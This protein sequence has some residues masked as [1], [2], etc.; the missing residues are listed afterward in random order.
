M[1][2]RVGAAIVDGAGL[3][4]SSEDRTHSLPERHLRTASMG[5]GKYWFATLS[6]KQWTARWGKR[7]TEGQ[8]KTFPFPNPDKARADFE[9]SVRKKLD[10]GYADSTTGAAIAQLTQRAAFTIKVTKKPGIDRIGGAA[11]ATPPVCKGCRKPMGVVAVF[12]A[13]AERL[14][15]PAGKALAIYMCETGGKNCKTWDPDAG[16]NAAVLLPKTAF[17]SGAGRLVHAGDGASTALRKG[18]THRAIC[19][20]ARSLEWFPTWVQDPEFPRDAR[21]ARR[22]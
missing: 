19:P 9:K 4:E 8:T 2:R 11:P 18:S 5:S 3:D 15:L 1:A 17:A 10:E 13:D 21:S 12:A 16:A 22:R 14:A 6:G 20:V 7:G